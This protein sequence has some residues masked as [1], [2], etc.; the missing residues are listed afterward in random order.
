MES[1]FLNQAGRRERNRDPHNR[2]I[3]YRPA[4]GQGKYERLSDAHAGL[5]TVLDVN[6]RRRKHLS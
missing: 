2:S 3:A 1:N 4:A 5:D 6:G